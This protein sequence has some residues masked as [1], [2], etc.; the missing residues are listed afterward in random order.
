MSNTRLKDGE[1]TVVVLM[2][3]T[4][5]KSDKIKACMNTADKTLKEAKE[6]TKKKGSSSLR[7]LTPGKEK[8]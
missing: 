7:I 1:D 5:S 2:D 8:S 4:L 6:Q 3:D